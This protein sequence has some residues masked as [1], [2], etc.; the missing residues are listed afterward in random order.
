MYITPMV[1]SQI[2]PS[3]VPVS[4]IVILI[5]SVIELGAI[6]VMRT[7][8]ILDPY[9]PRSIFM[10]KRHADSPI[11]QYP[12][13][14]HQALA[15]PRSKSRQKN[16]A[17]GQSI[18]SDKQRQASVS[19]ADETLP[20]SLKFDSE[21]ETCIGEPLIQDFAANN[22]PAAFRPFTSKESVQDSITESQPTPTG[23]PMVSSYEDPDTSSPPP[24]VVRKPLNI[25]S[26]TRQ[27]SPFITSLLRFSI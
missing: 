27:A 13:I 22:I 18:M 1:S 14:Q 25:Q 3:L 26:R 16:R 4:F 23:A 6:F 2:Q 17:S 19:S 5:V 15:D 12:A 24:E 11:E 21:E 20:A 8:R 7:A 10:R 9:R